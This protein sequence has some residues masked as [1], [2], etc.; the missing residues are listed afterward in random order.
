MKAL[1]GWNTFYQHSKLNNFDRFLNQDKD[2]SEIG[3]QWK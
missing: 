3:T 2:C 1:K